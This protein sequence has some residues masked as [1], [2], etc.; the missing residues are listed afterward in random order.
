[1]SRVSMASP[2]LS[3]R[4]LEALRA[5][6]PTADSILDEGLAELNAEIENTYDQEE[7][8]RRAAVDPTLSLAPDVNLD[9][10]LDSELDQMNARLDAQLAEQREQEENKAPE[11]EPEMTLQDCVIKTFRDLPGRPTD[12]QI[13]ALKSRY[14]EVNVIAFG[15]KDV[16]LYTYLRRSQFDRIREVV[17]KA[18]QVQGM[19]DPDRMLREKVLQSTV[20]WPKLTVEFFHGARAGTMDSLF[21]VIMLSSYFLTPQQAMQLTAQL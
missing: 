7:A 13:S 2:S 17:T 21:D 16:F 6:A 12:E 18:A 10:D 19:G 5:N 4:E 20:V 14:G 8:G 1:M 3:A 11:P 15:K 9:S